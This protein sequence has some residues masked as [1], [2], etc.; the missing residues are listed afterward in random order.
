MVAVTPQARDRQRMKFG[1][2]R[3]NVKVSPE[4]RN[5]WFRPASKISTVGAYLIAALALVLHFF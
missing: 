4:N 3:Y 5:W 2:Y 1:K